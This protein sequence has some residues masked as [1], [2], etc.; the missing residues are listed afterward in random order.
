MRSNWKF[1]E[2]RTV[3]KSKAWESKKMKKLIGRCENLQEEQ[4][5][6]DKKLSTG[7]T[8]KREHDD[9]AKEEAGSQGGEEF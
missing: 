9:G 8:T 1:A 7:K 5:E 6:A 3:T 4:Q 2:G